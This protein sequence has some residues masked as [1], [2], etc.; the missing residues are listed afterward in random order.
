MKTGIIL[1]ILM[2]SPLWSV[3]QQAPATAE[4]SATPQQS[5][6][7]TETKPAPEQGKTR[8]TEQFIPSETISEDLSVP[9]PVDI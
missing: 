1:L 5:P 9:F 8:P 4:E 3:A 7:S 6:Q 2:V